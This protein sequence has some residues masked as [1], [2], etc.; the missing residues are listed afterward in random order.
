MSIIS[1]KTGSCWAIPARIERL[2]TWPRL[3]S[4]NKYLGGLGLKMFHTTD[5]DVLQHVNIVLADLRKYIV[6][7]YEHEDD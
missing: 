6:E 4:G 2:A 5:F 1:L 3:R 7:H